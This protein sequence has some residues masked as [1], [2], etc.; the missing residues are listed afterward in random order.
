MNN[1]KH[2][3]PQQ[4]RASYLS[5][6]KTHSFFWVAM[7]FATASIPAFLLMVLLELVIKSQELSY[8]FFG[9]GITGAVSLSIFFWGLQTWYYKSY[10]QPAILLYAQTTASAKSSSAEFTIEGVVSRFLVK[11]SDVDSLYEFHVSEGN[12]YQRL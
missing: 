11:S 3:T 2:L 10:V 4:A 6:N 8:N 5:K 7:F 12:L 9:F 1:T